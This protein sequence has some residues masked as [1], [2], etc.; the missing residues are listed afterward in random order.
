MKT[1]VRIDDALLSEAKAHA[2]RTGRSLTS[3]LEDA[4]RML[5]TQENSAV[6]SSTRATA[7]PTFG[8]GGLR[9]GVSLDGSAALLDLM[10]G[11][12]GTD[13]EAR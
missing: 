8:K 12:D 5:L 6:T 10:D 4:V 1:I 13:D 3:L 11:I 2:A 7:L 9:E